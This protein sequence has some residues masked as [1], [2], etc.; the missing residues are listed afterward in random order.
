[1]E[2]N[3]NLQ[4]SVSK[5]MKKLEEFDIL[6]DRFDRLRLQYKDLERTVQQDSDD[7]DIHKDLWINEKEYYKEIIRKL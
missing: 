1:M 2:D 5:G 7:W 3:H 4:E 6:Q